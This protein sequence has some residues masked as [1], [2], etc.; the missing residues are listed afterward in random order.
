VTPAAT[1]PDNGAIFAAMLAYALASLLYVAGKSR[2]FRAAGRAAV[3]AGAVLLAV[4][5]QDQLIS[6]GNWGASAGPLLA[7]MIGAGALAADRWLGVRLVP[8]LLVPLGMLIL[9]VRFFAAPAPHI[10]PSPWLTG[11]HVTM[12]LAGQAMAITACVL[13]ALYLWQ[14]R[15][16]KQRR[17][18]ELASRVPS[19]ER[20]DEC[21]RFALVTGF[22]TLTLSLITGALFM[23]ALPP[24]ISAG[25]L[26]ALRA[27]IL[28]AISVWSW[29]LATLVA[30]NILRSPVRIVARMSVG[31]FVLMSLAWF[32]LIFLANRPNLTIPLAG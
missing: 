21:L 23:T 25:M 29:Y 13:S 7:A 22:I 19:L 15:A 5:A 2:F 17:I 8:A 1:F 20:L 18:L 31:G 10:H 30:R 32:G 9:L 11:F 6:T 16:L 26:L 28:W 12:A 4:S 24:G 3:V 14:H 27:K